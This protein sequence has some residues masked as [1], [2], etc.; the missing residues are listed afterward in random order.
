M[1]DDE[2]RRLL[3][4]PVRQGAYGVSLRLFR[5]VSE[6]RSAVAFTSLDRLASVLGAGQAWIRLAESALRSLTADI[7]VTRIV[8]DPSGT[9][10]P[11]Q[12]PAAAVPL[13]AA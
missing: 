2:T 5:T 13:R 8:I 11:G 3:F 4:V 10:A 9:N 1:D 6:P 12:R 7:G